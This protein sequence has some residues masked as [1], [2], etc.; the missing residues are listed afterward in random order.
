MLQPSQ[1]VGLQQTRLINTPTSIKSPAAFSSRHVV[2]LPSLP[3]PS[4][5]VCLVCFSSWGSSLGS[6]YLGV[7]C[8]SGVVTNFHTYVSSCRYTRSVKEVVSPPPPTNKETNK[9]KQETNK[10]TNQRLKYRS[11]VVTN[12]HTYV[13]RCRYTR[14]VKEVVFP[15]PP[16][17]KQRNKQNKK[18]TNKQTNA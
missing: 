18:Q 10:Q 2:C 15:P 16:P 4:I 1:T 8:R 7:R 13:S 6:L 12:F 3:L 5:H 14:S 11:V 9:T 17:N